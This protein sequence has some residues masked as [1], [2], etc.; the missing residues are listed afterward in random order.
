M[1]IRRRR[2]QAVTVGGVTIGGGA[3]VSV[4][5]MT[6]TPTSDARA[7]IAQIGSL[8]RAGA[9]IVRVSVPDDASASALRSIVAESC[10]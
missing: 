9:Q 3:P 2:S 5:S 1:R 4:Q 8:A 6:N 10:V 7:T